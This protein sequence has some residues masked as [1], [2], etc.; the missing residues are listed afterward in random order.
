[1]L[2]KR[3]GRSDVEMNRG[4]KDN[5]LIQR[6]TV[7]LHLR[8][9]HT[10]SFGVSCFKLWQVE[11][12]QQLHI[13]EFSQLVE[14]CALITKISH[15]TERGAQVQGLAVTAVFLVSEGVSV[16]AL[17]ATTHHKAQFPLLSDILCVALK[18]TPAPPSHM[19][20]CRLL[21]YTTHFHTWSC[22]HKFHTWL[23]FTGWR[24]HGIQINIILS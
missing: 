13:Q 16:S 2:L 21:V 9:C 17:C 11:K 19:H 22:K 23:I 5:N 1:M 4:L 8:F 14:M 12:L 18:K 7:F 24:N 10:L 6:H 3:K 15:D 20:R